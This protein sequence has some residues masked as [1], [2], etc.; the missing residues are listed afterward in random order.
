MPM[1]GRMQ[2]K[3]YSLGESDFECKQ[4]QTKTESETLLVF[5]NVSDILIDRVTTQYMRLFFYTGNKV[6]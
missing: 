5:K 3:Q 1:K 4:M 2:Q 6:G